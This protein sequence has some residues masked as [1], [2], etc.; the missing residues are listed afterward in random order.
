MCRDS[1]IARNMIRFGDVHRYGSEPRFAAGSAVAPLLFHDTDIGAA[2]AERRSPV[3]STEPSETVKAKKATK[4]NADGLRVMG[5]A[6][7]IDHLGTLVRN[8]MR[9]PLR[10]R[11]CFTLHSKPT[12]LQQ[13]A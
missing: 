13:A 8:T 6:E 2:K 12:P 10:T 11:H 5:F 7:L 1:R 3:A 4:R 9:M